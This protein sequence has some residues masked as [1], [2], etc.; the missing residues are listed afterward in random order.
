[1]ICIAYVWQRHRTASQ[2]MINKLLMECYMV[3]CTQKVQHQKLLL[4]HWIKFVT[5]KVS[6]ICVCTAC[7]YI[8]FIPTATLYQCPVISL[9][10]RWPISWM[11]FW[12][13]LI[14]QRKVNDLKPLMRM[15]MIWSLIPYCVGIPL[16]V[17]MT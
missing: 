9:E 17:V 13:F 4:S 10:T 12:A 3:F 8:G 5:H 7:L 1:M 15:K 2:V 6:T 16:Y 11:L 14:G